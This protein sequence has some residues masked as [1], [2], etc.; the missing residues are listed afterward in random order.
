MRVEDI[1]IDC[2][3][4]PIA[5]GQEETRR[6]AL[7]TLE[8][9]SELK[10]RHP[11]VQTTLGLSNVSFGLNPAARQVLN[12]VFL[13]E[14]VKAGLDSAIVHPSK[15]LPMSRIPDEQPRGRPRPDLRPPT[16]RA[17]TRCSA[18][19]SSSRAPRRR[20][21][22]R[23]GP[24]SSPACRCSSGSSDASSTASATASRPTST[25]RCSTRP[26][27]EIVNDTLL[28]GHEDRGRAV[29]L[30]PDAA[31]VRAAERRGHED[32][33]RLP[34]AAHGAHRRL[35]Q[36]HDRAGHRQG[37]RARHR[38][39]PRRH[40]PEQQRLHGRQPRHQAADQRHPRRGRGA[41]RRRHRDVRAAGE[42]H[43]GHEGEPRGAEPA[44]GRRAVAGPARRGGADPDLRRAGPGGDLRRRGPL[45]PGRLRGAA[46]DGRPG[47]APTRGTGDG[48]LPPLR[49]R[50]VGRGSRG[51]PGGPT[52]RHAGP[53]RRGHRQPG[54]RPRRSGA[55]GSSRASRWPSTRPGS[56]SARSS[57]ASGASSPAAATAG[58]PTRS[59]WRPRAGR[60][61]GTGWTGSR[62][63][64]C[65]RRRWSTA[66]SRA[67]ARATTS[68]CCSD[69]GGTERCRFT[70]PRQRRDRHLCLSDFFRARE[71]GEVDVVGVPRRHH[72]QPHQSRPP[73]SCSPRTPIATTSSCTACRCSSPRRW[74]STG[75][76]GSAPSSASATR[77]PQTSTQ[78]LAPGV[79]RLALLLRLP[80]LP[81]PRGPGP[82]HGAAAPG[83]D[84]R[85]PVRGVPA[86][87]RAVDVRAG[88]PPPRGQVLQRPMT[89]SATAT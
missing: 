73:T 25:R 28:D 5:T 13:A 72:G 63:R 79:P 15:I 53:L 48:R 21:R 34:R 70:F 44:R 88:R 32:R 38:Q 60:G 76:R 11:D 69:D 75:T 82:G 8:A 83:A 86:A 47:G 24:R 26:A 40:H 27:L 42:V 29:R 12:S 17:T 45:R 52:L 30:G 36:G 56:T 54:A 10:R 9:I 2:L 51:R 39:E 59:W 58:P 81:G 14:A 87:P 18:S 74:P 22:P 6:D 33:G 7:E 20:P 4:F 57:W 43:G 64:A 19:S 66:T 65:S 89:S 78:M 16:R 3:T 23:P 71:S 85:E 77:T 61:C 67:G 49:P 50:R 35:R 84:R 62:P 68:S 80:G 41:R 1:V 37:R 46:A 31:A 55:T